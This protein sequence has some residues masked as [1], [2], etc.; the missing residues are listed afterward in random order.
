MVLDLRA[1][2]SLFEAGLAREVAMSVFIVHFTCTIMS[3][4]SGQHF[5]YYLF[6][7]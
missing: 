2:E 3:S 5:L 1:D 4:I 7:T 6:A